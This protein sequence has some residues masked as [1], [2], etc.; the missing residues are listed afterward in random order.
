MCA[1]FSEFNCCLSTATSLYRLSTSA[2][3]F[4]C[5]KNANNL[6]GNV[7]EH[8][9]HKQNTTCSSA[10][11]LPSL[12]HFLGISITSQHLQYLEIITWLAA[13][14]RCFSLACS[15][16]HSSSSLRTRFL[17]SLF[18]CNHKNTPSVQMPL[19]RDLYL[20]HLMP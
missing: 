10:N 15:C 3:R 17:S 5:Y 20:L 1:C 2:L 6:S 14:T 8:T 19:I 18:P 13:C 9:V 7:L 16:L 11:R 4:C 12:Y